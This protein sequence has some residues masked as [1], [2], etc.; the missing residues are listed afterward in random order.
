MIASLLFA[1]LSLICSSQFSI[2]PKLLLLN[3]KEPTP[4]AVGGGLKMGVKVG[5]Q[6]YLSVSGGTTLK[7][8]ENVDRT[9]GDPRALASGGVPQRNVGRIFH[10]RQI[11]LFSAEWRSKDQSDD[12]H[13]AIGLGAGYHR[14]QRDVDLDITLLAT[15][16]THR[17]TY[18]AVDP[19]FIILPYAGWRAPL[20]NGEF[21]ADAGAM[22][23]SLRFAKDLLPI[24][25]TGFIW[26]LGG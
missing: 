18:S 12:D 14:Y 3:Q 7:E 1:G 17:N 6:W 4:I 19:S 2:G 16:L 20:L 24:L 10:Q 9:W 26:P 11:I 15:G 8:R 21:F 23:P 5:S 13:W 25:R 22:L